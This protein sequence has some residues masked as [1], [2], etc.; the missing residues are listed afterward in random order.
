MNKL[1]ILF[2]LASIGLPALADQHLPPDKFEWG[3]ALALIHAPDYPGSR[4]SQNYLLPFPYL[5]YR[6]KILRIDDGVEA[7]LF[8]QPGL[9]LSV[10]GN[11]SLPSPK[12]NDERQGMPSLDASVEFG[13]SLEYRLHQGEGQSLWLEL[14]LRVALTVSQKPT[15]FGR[16]FTPRLAWRKP[17]LDKYSW[18]L[19]LAAGPL[20]AS[21]DFLDH[22]YAVAAD[23]ATPTRAQYSAQSGFNGFR[24]DFT[25]SRRIGELWLGGFIR[26]DSLAGSVIEDSPLLSQTSNVTAGVSLAWVISER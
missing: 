11:G 20:Y 10:S 16:V 17:A 14:P 12:Q 25:F 9:L 2:I 22:Y 7:R 19:R 6:G 13:P 5:K 26:H 18:K 3:P 15:M 21:K 24:T 8:H 23:E 1:L 4:H